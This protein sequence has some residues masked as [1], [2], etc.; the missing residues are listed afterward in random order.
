M[1]RAEVLESLKPYPANVLHV[2]SDGVVKLPEFIGW[3]HS[4]MVIGSDKKIFQCD[5]PSFSAI[6]SIAGRRMSGFSW[7][8]E[9]LMT[10][11]GFASVDKNEHFR[12]ITVMDCGVE[13]SIRE[14]PAMATAFGYSE[15][16]HQIVA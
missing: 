5:D 2:G 15:T 4:F 6:E 1:T 11:F 13:N 12:G 10:P 14:R 7:I 16:I 3:L 8:G 9:R